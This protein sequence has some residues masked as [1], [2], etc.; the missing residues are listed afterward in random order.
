[1]CRE[2]PS[3]RMCSRGSPMATWFFFEMGYLPSLCI[4]RCTQLPMATW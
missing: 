3:D 2:S 1:V 4:N